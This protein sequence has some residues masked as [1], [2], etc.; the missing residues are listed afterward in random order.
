MGV[1][2]LTIGVLLAPL[3]L[4]AACGG[5]VSGAPSARS[6]IL[7]VP[8]CHKPYTPYSG[9]YARARSELE[10]QTPDGQVQVATF[11]SVSA[12]AAWFR[13][14]QVGTCG[15]IQGHGWAAEI[16]AT[17]LDDCGLTTRWAR[18]LGGRMVSAP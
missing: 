2:A 10:C 5:G 15:N 13:S 3:M 8:G 7:R 1:R 18:V 17:V 9:V 6:L 16:Y 4:L 14:L 11:G 12:E